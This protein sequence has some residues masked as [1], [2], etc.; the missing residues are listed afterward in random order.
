MKLSHA[1]AIFLLWAI[2][3]TVSAD[4]KDR[5]MVNS[6][7]RFYAE[8]LPYLNKGVELREKGDLQRARTCFDAAIRIDKRLWPAYLDRAQI[9]AQAGQWELALQDCNTAARLRPDF[10]RTFIMRA[11]VYGGMGRCRDGLADLDRVVSFHADSESNALA[12][13]QRARLRAICRDPAVRDPKLAV[14][15]AKQ[16]CDLTAWKKASYIG[17]LA[18]A[19]A[20]SGDFQSAVRYEQQAI[21]SG[22]HSAEELREAKQRLSQYEHRQLR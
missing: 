10:Y 1:F 22:K 12:L 5:F 19:C 3:A 16:A 18:I 13:S 14:A 6:R 20:S 17:T 8:A 2:T 21:N 11:T 9:F 15:D 4:K 7:G